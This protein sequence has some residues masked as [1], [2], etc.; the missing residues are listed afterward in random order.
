MVWRC[1]LKQLKQAPRSRPLNSQP[2]HRE[3]E[4][5]GE[6]GGEAEEGEEVGEGEEE[7]EELAGPS[8]LVFRSISQHLRHDRQKNN[9]A[10]RRRGPSEL[11]TAVSS[12]SSPGTPGEKCPRSLKRTDPARPTGAALTSFRS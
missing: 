8:A 11:L 10:T 6:E 12:P 7:E 5:E 1:Q 9:K 3:A 2:R 4:E